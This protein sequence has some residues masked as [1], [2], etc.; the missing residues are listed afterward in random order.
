MLVDLRPR[1]VLLR[2]DLLEL[3][4]H[5]SKQEV[6]AFTCMACGK[7]CLTTWMHCISFSINA[8]HGGTCFEAANIEASC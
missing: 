4:W 2:L 1:Q 8:K 3:G 7:V 6:T 5:W